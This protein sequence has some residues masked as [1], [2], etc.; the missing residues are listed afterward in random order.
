M[1]ER[2]RMSTFAGKDGRE[3]TN[4]V[5]IDDYH[6]VQWFGESSQCPIS[7][8]IGYSMKSIATQF[9][10]AVVTLVAEDDDIVTV[11]CKVI[12]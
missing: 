8:D 9:R 1:Y 11:L 4:L 2:I 12:I 5:F 3:W 6:V 7:N 10:N